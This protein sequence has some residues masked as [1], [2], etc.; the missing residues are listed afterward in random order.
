MKFVDIPH[1]ALLGKKAILG[2]PTSPGLLPIGN[3]AFYDLIQQGRFPRP[4][5]IGR[6]SV[7][8]AGEVLAAISKLAAGE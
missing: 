7:W 1:N 4:R 6:R 5:K 2:N 3:T 8:V